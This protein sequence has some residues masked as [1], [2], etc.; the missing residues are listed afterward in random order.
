MTC[1]YDRKREKLH[2]FDR[3][4][5]HLLFCQTPNFLNVLSKMLLCQNKANNVLSK[6]KKILSNSD[7]YLD[8]LLFCQSLQ[9]CLTE[10]FYCLTEILLR[11]RFVWQNIPKMFK[12]H[13]S[14]LI[15]GMNQYFEKSPWQKLQN[16]ISQLL[17]GGFFDWSLSLGG[18]QTSS[19]THYIPQLLLTELNLSLSGQI[20]GNC[21]RLFYQQESILNGL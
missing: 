19:R 13:K 12:N 16:H 9:S 17:S 14:L 7:G 2:F 21:S 1:V 10:Q 4:F 5:H 11:A 15:S 8:T 6:F 18:L 20:V 3:T